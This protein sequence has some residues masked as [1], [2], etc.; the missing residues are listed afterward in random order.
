MK[1]GVGLTDMCTGLYLHG[2][3]LAALRSRDVTGHGQQVDTSLFE[4]Q[5]SLLANVAMSWL[6]VGQEGR[7]W[8]TA[9]P[10]IVPY[11]CFKTADSYFVVGAVNDRQFRTLCRILCLE[12]LVQDDRFVDNVSRVKNR[13][14]L[15][16]ML[17]STF[18]KRRTAEWMTKFEGSGMPYGPINTME[19]VF[20]HPQTISREMV[21]TVVDESSKS[22]NVQLLGMMT[23]ISVHHWFSV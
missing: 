13:Q 23:S 1:P 18:S 15:G 7:R 10:S 6:N 19:Q 21:E 8:G 11:D 20:A 12:H 3:I 22:G 2:A 4:T 14:A 17:N 9:H 5:V 16:E